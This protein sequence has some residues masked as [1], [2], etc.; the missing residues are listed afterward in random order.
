MVPARDI[1]FHRLW[2]TRYHFLMESDILWTI[3]G[4]INLK[5][6]LNSLFIALQNE[7]HQ[8]H[9]FC[10]P[11]FCNL[12]VTPDSRKIRE[13]P[14]IARRILSVSGLPVV[15]YIPWLYPEKTEKL[16]HFATLLLL[17]A[18]PWPSHSLRCHDS[19][20]WQEET[21]GMNGYNHTMTRFKCERK[22]MFVMVILENLSRHL[23]C[24]G[25]TWK[26]L[27]LFLCL[28][29]LLGQARPGQARPG[30]LGQGWPSKEAALFKWV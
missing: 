1:I 7:Y 8:Y 20:F 29:C 26:T 25:N 24:H 28:L 14:R 23:N 6:C 11:T 17:F 22:C 13:Q 3:G 21:G 16:L 27:S 5:V 9:V 10:Y 15:V 30:R 18:L 19:T 2:F 4:R 12:M